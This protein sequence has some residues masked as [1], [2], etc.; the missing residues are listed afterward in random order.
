LCR[1]R[2]R[3]DLLQRLPHRLVGRLVYPPAAD[4]EQNVTH[5]GHVCRRDPV[6]DVTRGV[7]RTIEYVNLKGAELEDISLT[8]GLVQPR[9]LRGLAPGTDDRAVGLRLELRIS[10]GVIRVIMRGKDVRQAP[11]LLV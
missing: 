7:A 6:D 11:T 3:H 2:Q 1:R 10:A 8:D 9:Y 4:G 5:E